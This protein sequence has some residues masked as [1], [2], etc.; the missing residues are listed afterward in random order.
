M[1]N[2][3]RFFFCLCGF[4]GFILFFSLGWILAGNAFDAL[5]RGSIG[6][7]AFGVGGRILLGTLLRSLLQNSSS[8]GDGRL[9]SSGHAANGLSEIAETTPTA[10]ELAMQASTQATSEAAA[11]VEPG[12]N[13]SA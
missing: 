5:L 2:D 8:V 3:A 13:T 12:V 11:G 4:A 7:L 10:E 9:N 6:C 1:N